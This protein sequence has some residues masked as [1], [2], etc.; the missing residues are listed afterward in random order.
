MGRNWENIKIASVKKFNYGSLRTFL[1]AEIVG[2][3]IHDFKVVQQPNQKAYARAPEA[4]WRDA[5]NVTHYKPIVEFF[6]PLRSQVLEAV[7]DAYAD[8][9]KCSN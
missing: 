9:G 5:R 4:S 1:S 6:E 8:A 2:V 7:L 3:I